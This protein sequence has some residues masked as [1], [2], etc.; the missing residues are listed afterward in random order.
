MSG[1]DKDVSVKLFSLMVIRRVEIEERRGVTI[2]A[3][4][5]RTP[6]FIADGD[7]IAK[8]GQITNSGSQALAVE[9]D[10]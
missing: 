9:S 8:L 3:V 10:V 4:A 5:E 7:L 6:V 2:V 1:L